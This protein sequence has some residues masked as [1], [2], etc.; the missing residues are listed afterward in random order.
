[1]QSGDSHQIGFFVISIPPGKWWDNKVGHNGLKQPLQCISQ[2]SGSYE[3]TIEI[4][5]FGVSEQMVVLFWVKY[6]SRLQ[7]LI[8]EITATVENIIKTLGAM[9]ENFKTSLKHWVQ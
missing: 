7:Q 6:P 8:Q 2:C 4:N 9:M 1:L 5:E 3:R